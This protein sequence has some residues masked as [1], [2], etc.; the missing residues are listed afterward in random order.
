MQAAHPGRVCSGAS[1]GVPFGLLRVLRM[2][3]SS[4]FAN[5]FFFFFF[6]FFINTLTL[7]LFSL[8]PFSSHRRP[9]S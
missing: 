6:F 8:S 9:E 2:L 1:Q 7:Y 3:L 4:S 5:P